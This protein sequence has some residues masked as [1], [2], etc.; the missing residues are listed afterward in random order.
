MK[1]KIIYGVLLFC[2][3]LTGKIQAQGNTA[4]P[5]DEVGAQ[6][7]AV[8]ARFFT[9]YSKDRV[10]KEQMGQRALCQYVCAVL[11]ANN[12]DVAQALATNATVQA[13]QGMAPTEA[14]AYLQAK[15]FV[16][17]LF[18]DYVVK[19]DR[20]LSQYVG[21]SYG[22]LHNAVVGIEG[23]ILADTKLNENERKTLLLTS[24]VARH[25]AR[26]WKN[27]NEGQ[28]SYASIGPNAVSIAKDSI[29][30]I[31]RYDLMGAMLG[32]MLSWWTWDLEI[33][34]K[35]TAISA[36]VFSIGAGV[37]TFWKWLIR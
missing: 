22:P 28:T 12:C 25:S 24:S 26:F 36:G 15:G 30:E 19:L 20:S 27:L 21:T 17:G 4:N 3:S 9:E 8:L 31:I 18:T 33:F 1:A 11:Q 37:H 13:T 34:V 2:L 6:H 10:V 14:A 32:G 7:N 23:Q 29:N 5:Y 35:T 16:G